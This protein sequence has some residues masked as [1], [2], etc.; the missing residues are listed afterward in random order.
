[1]RFLKVN[2]LA[3]HLDFVL[4]SFLS[5]LHKKQYSILH[6]ETFKIVTIPNKLFVP[7]FSWQAAIYLYFLIKGVPYFITTSNGRNLQWKRFIWKCQCKAANGTFVPSEAVVFVLIKI[8]LIKIWQ[9]MR[10]WHQAGWEY[11]IRNLF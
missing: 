11:W 5:T 4:F 8:Y 2:I 3:R 9:Q 7:V 6:T 1:M 10:D